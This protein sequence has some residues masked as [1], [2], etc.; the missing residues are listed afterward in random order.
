MKTTT[1]EAYHTAQYTSEELLLYNYILLVGPLTTI[2][3][4]GDSVQRAHGI[5][6]QLSSANSSENYP[7]CM[8]QIRCPF[9]LYYSTR[10]LQNAFL[11]ILSD[12]G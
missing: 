5:V 12:A 9:D 10:M 8:Y 3:Q 2:F 11:F 1:S 7:V 6:P 4:C